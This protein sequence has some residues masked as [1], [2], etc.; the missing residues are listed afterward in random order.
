M[1]NHF[2]TLT[3]PLQR[4]LDDAGFVEPTPIQA[5]AI[6]VAIAG[7][8]ILAS[9]QTGSGKTAAFTLP[10]L[11]RLSQ[12]RGRARPGSPRALILAPTRELAHQIGEVFREL[13]HHLPLRRLVIFGGVGKQ[14]Q[15][16]NLRRGVDILVATPGRLLDLMNTGD[17][18]LRDI[19]V[20]VLD[21]ADRMLDMGFI[22]DVKRII[23]ALPQRRQSLFFSATLPTEVT[24]LAQ[25]MLTDPQQIEIARTVETTPRIDQTLLFVDRSNKRELLMNLLAEGNWSRTIVFTRT[26]Y[27]AR[28]LER[29]LSRTGVSVDSLHG[30]KS[31][32]ARRRALDGFSSGRIDV[33]VATD[34][35]SRGLDVD[36]VTHVINYELPHEP[37][38]YVHRIGRT[39]RAGKEGSAV[40]FCDS[41][42]IKQLVDI[43]KLLKERVPVDIDHPFHCQEA[44]RA[45]NAVD[46]RAGGAGRNRRGGGGGPGR[47]RSRNNHRGRNQR[48]KPRV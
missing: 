44:Q 10:I 11:H 9:A 27:G 30:D 37:E 48:T 6:P 40:S 47:P 5:Q 23:A 39:A 28:N 22:P 41:T 36:D 15:V 7:N 32:T 8:D 33:L 24:G 26:K 42:E 34:I 14:P 35:A 38:V 21:E 46:A 3:E 17:V 1:D 45:R 31:Q 16:K 13:G 29:R 43:E 20:V 18:T 2:L 12:E 19:E 25:S 4:A